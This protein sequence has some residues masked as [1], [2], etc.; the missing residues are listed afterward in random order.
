MR[1]IGFRESE[2]APY[3][4]WRGRERRRH[5]RAPQKVSTHFAALAEL[6]RG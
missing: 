5:A 6:K 2:T 1:D 4:I 3:W